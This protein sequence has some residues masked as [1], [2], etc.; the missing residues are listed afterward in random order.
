MR[1]NR[2]TESCQPLSRPVLLSLLLA[3]L[4]SSQAYAHDDKMDSMV[5]PTLTLDRLEWRAGAG[6]DVL[7]WEGALRIGN[8]SNAFLWRSKGEQLS[9]GATE[10]AENQLLWQHMVSEFFNLHT[11]IRQDQRPSPTRSYAVIGVDGL[12]P[13]WIETN[14]D[15]YV[16]DQ[17]RL[18]AR[19]ELAHDLAI[20][21]RLS[22]QPALEINA[23][24]DDD[25]AIDE[26]AGVTRSEL[27]L[28]LRYAVTPDIAPYIGV[29]W[30]Q[31]YG[32]TADL[33]RHHG[34]R[35][36]TTYG[37]VGISLSF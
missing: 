17:G 23:A 5:I 9:G 8:D 16:S 22:L 15:L 34:E 14:A 33:A 30:E 4:L 26:G 24:A 3:G 11:G 13:Y 10:K 35:T 18:S 1:I 29:H 32:K 19:L 6:S 31:M 37:L 25:L 36:A 2:Q 21:S 27:G 20:T 7:A 12:A 28:R